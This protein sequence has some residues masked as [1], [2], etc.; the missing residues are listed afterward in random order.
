MPLRVMSLLGVK[1]V[2]V[3]GA[4]GAINTDYK[5][6]DMVIITDHLYFPGFAGKGPLMGPNDD[7]FGKRF[8]PLK[9][10]YDP[11][12]IEQFEKCASLIPNIPNIRKGI[13]A[14]IGGPHFETPAEI[15]FLRLV[16]FHLL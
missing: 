10:C 15:R 12:L 5:L 7:R 16:F 9:D 4:V 11:Q 14:C 6:G 1:Y 8:V 13:Y 2:M 3:T